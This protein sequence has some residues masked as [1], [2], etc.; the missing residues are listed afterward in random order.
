MAM[1][2]SGNG[3]TVPC[4]QRCSAA[5]PIAASVCVCPNQLFARCCP[6]ISALI[7]FIHVFMVN[8]KLRNCNTSNNTDF[9][10]LS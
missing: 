6:A 8:N 9:F 10:P 5:L 2:L 7:P 1:P 4:G 3:A